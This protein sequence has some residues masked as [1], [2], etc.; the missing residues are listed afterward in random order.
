MD[1][2]TDDRPGGNRSRARAGGLAPGV[3]LNDRYEIEAPLGAGVYGDL[4]QAK[5]LADGRTVTVKVLS[6]ALIADPRVQKRLEREVQIATQLD[7]KNIG[8]TYGLY[9]AQVGA[10]AIAYLACEHIDGQT[11]RDMVAKKRSSARTFSLKGTY[12][13]IAHLCNALVYAHGATIHGAISTDSVFVNSAGR[14]KVVDFGLART[15]RPMDV[16]SGMLASFAPEMATAP[17]EAD[18]RAD[19]YAVGVILYELLCGKPPSETFEAPSRLVPG[20]PPA[21]DEVVERCLR[22]RP[23]DRFPDAQTLKEALHAALAAELDGV[24]TTAAVPIAASQPQAQPPADSTPIST[25]K[26]LAA[27]APPPK[28]AAPPPPAR[29]AAPPPPKPAAPPPPK[30]AAP[31]PPK[32]AAPPPPVAAAPTPPAAAPKPVPSQ[33]PLAK[34]FDVDAALS[35]VD[36]QTERWLVQKDKLDFGPFSLREVRSQ[37]ESGKILAEHTLID[38]ETGERRKVKEHP[39]LRQLV[40]EAEAKNAEKQREES[41]RADRQKQRGRVVILLGA[42]LLIVLGVG[43]GV[44]WYV[45]NMKPK[46]KI[47]VKE[48]TI[49]DLDFLK[50][51]EISMKVDPPPPKTPGVKKKRTGGKNEFSDVTSLGDASEGGGDETLDQSQV[52]RVMQSN[53]KVLVG[54]IGEERKRNPGLKSIDMDFIIKGTGS[55][56]AVKVNGATNTPLA[57]CMYGKMQSVA[58]PKFNGAKTH[59]SFSLNLK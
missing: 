36:D 55:V 6:P 46:E 28:P 58:F 40:L 30:P 29:A 38:T 24:K 22:P 5:D 34:S 52:Q 44:T 12:N 49:D 7:H 39:A 53:F 32:P 48:K 45:L 26:P 20:I 2:T 56:S 51:I 3:R 17:D 50:G 59:A 10:E 47:I 19:L 14:V 42:I 43:G 54:C 21:V 13:V 57:S 31:P 4:Y 15:L 18:A 25:E 37:I 9:G 41:E 23:Q 33:P 35:S 1:M 11:L 27:A 8:A 16:G